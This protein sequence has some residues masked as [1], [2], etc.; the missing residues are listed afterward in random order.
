M[1]ILNMPRGTGKTSQLFFKAEKT[2][3]PI[4]VMS[5]DNKE[6]CSKTYGNRFISLEEYFEMKPSERPQKIYIDESF[7]IL[8]RIFKD[9]EI[10]ATTFS[11]EEYNSELWILMK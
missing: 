2:D 10:I 11:S 9:S 8:K 4:I 3:I 5:K 6:A 1:K 7:E